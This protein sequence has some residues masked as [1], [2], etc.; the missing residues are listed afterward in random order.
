MGHSK[1]KGSSTWTRKTRKLLPSEYRTIFLRKEI[2][3][4]VV[5]QH[6]LRYFGAPIPKNEVERIAKLR[7]L[8]VLDTQNTAPRTIQVQLVAGHRDTGGPA[9]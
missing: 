7:S 4:Q 3:P 9:G 5:L 1:R 8:E 2:E 6:L